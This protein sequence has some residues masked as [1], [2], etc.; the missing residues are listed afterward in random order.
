M[1]DVIVPKAVMWLN[2]GTDAD[3]VSALAY[4]ERENQS[5]VDGEM[6]KRCYVSDRISDPLERARVL[7]L[8]DIPQ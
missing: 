4:C 3:L 5:I 2:D 1:R 6:A 8:Q 7:Y